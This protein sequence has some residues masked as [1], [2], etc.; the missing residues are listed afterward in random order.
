MKKRRDRPILKR[1]A[2]IFIIGLSAALQY[3]VASHISIAGVLPNLMLVTAV[4][5]GYTLGS[6]AGGFSGICL[7]LYQDAQ[8]GKILGMYALFFL[9]AGVI[10]GLFP[11]KTNAGDLPTALIAVYAITVLYEG[12]VYL[13]AYALPVLQSGFVPGMDLPHAVILVIIPAAFLNSLCSIPYYFILRPRG[14]VQESIENR[15]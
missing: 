5:A 3:N 2:L 8:S 7:G 10:A 6:E 12:A 1:I 4:T 9:Y 11:K 15:G 13:F 14:I